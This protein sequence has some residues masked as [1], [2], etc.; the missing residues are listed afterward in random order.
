MLVVILGVGGRRVVVALLVQG[1]GFVLGGWTTVVRGLISIVVLGVGGRGA[2]VVL[3]VQ[4]RGVLGG[5]TIVV[6]RLPTPLVGSGISFP[7]PITGGG[8]VPPVG[9][10]T[11]VGGTTP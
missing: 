1:T 7:I 5:W 6:R 2:V 9:A 11:P 10:Q 8:I 3:L 4:G